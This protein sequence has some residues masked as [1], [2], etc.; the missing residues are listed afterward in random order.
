[1][2]QLESSEYTKD[3]HAK[4]IVRKRESKRESKIAVSKPVHPSLLQVADKVAKEI[5]KIGS[6]TG[7]TFDAD[8]EGFVIK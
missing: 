1:M 2:A 7:I 5:N 8:G 3:L 6:K 4:K